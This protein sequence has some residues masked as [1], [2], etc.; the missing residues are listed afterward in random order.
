MKKIKGYNILGI[1]LALLLVFGAKQTK[2]SNVISVT[3]LAGGIVGDVNCDGSV[4]TAD[5]TAIYNYLLEGDPTFMATSDVDGDG[6]ITTT[7]ITVIYN[8][9]LGAE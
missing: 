7:D 9:L 8:I 5:V 3:T 2:W 6:F 4:T 1:V